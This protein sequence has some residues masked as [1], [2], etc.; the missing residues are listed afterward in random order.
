M[1][2]QKGHRAQW[3]LLNRSIIIIIII[4]VVVVRL[5]PGPPPVAAARE[6]R[7]VTM[8]ARGR[9]GGARSSSRGRR[10]GVEGAAVWGDE[11]MWPLPI[12]VVRADRRRAHSVE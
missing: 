11:K 2:I 3:K 5:L 8:W 12:V 4:V 1:F 9:R 7:V 6:L 10:R